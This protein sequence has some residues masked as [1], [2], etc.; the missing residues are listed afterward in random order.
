MQPS[1]TCCMHPSMQPPSTS[2]TPACFS[3]LHC[4]PAPLLATPAAALHPLFP[5]QNPTQQR[6][7]LPPLAPPTP[8]RGSATFCSPASCRP[9]LSLQHQLLGELRRFL[10]EWLPFLHHAWKVA[11]TAGAF[12]ACRGESRFGELHGGSACNPSCTS[13]WLCEQRLASICAD[14][15]VQT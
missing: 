7:K 3:P 15:C 11:C 6:S 4:N 8:P 12:D 10:A 2:C 1:C 9:Y 5:P 13:A 14:L